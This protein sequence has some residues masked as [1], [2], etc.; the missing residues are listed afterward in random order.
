MTK[1]VPFP[2][3]WCFLPSAS[4]TASCS[5]SW[6]VKA[7]IP[8]AVEVGGRIEP[9][10]AWPLRCPALP[11]ARAMGEALLQQPLCQKNDRHGHGVK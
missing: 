10:D 11:T 7:R 1:L 4:A 8:E 5:G 6:A 9:H 2:A 3:R